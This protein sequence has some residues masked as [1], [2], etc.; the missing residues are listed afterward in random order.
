MQK[1]TVAQLATQRGLSLKAAWNLVQRE[2]W[3][4]TEDAVRGV[5]VS[6][7]HNKKEKVT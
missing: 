6:V 7:P 2:G 4:W 5:M 3:C 1:L